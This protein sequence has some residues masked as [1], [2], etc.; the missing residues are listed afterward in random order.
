[1]TPEGVECEGEGRR[2]LEKDWVQDSVMQRCTFKNNRKASPLIQ[3]PLFVVQEKKYR[4]RKIDGW[5]DER[6]QG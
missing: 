4:K 2:I 1:M 6:K 3:D 5:A